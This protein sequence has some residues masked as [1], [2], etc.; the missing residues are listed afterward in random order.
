MSQQWK[1]KPSG[2]GTKL[3][4]Y[5]KRLKFRLKFVQSKISAQIMK[6]KFVF[7]FNVIKN[8]LRVLKNQD[9]KKDFWDKHWSCRPAVW[10]EERWFA[11]NR[12]FTQHQRVLNDL[13]HQIP[14]C[15]SFLR[16]IVSLLLL[17]RYWVQ[18]LLR[19][20]EENTGKASC[21]KLLN[22]PW[23]LCFCSCASCVF[24]RLFFTNSAGGFLGVAADP[25]HRGGKMFYGGRELLQ[26]PVLTC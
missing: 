4:F 21:L 8:L 12:T 14:S 13:S 6:K 25:V 2:E 7:F 18:L 15:T 23:R 10:Y 24:F 22:V 17:Q 5:L 1:K 16:V 19:L 3:F 9:Q 11:C 20:W 26:T